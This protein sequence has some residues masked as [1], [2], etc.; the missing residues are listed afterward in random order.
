M[1]WLASFPRSG[2]TFFRNVLYEV[3]G[4]ESSTFHIEDHRE[5]DVNYDAYPVA[6]THLLPDQLQP[7]DRSIPSVYIVRDGR[8][9]LVSLAHHR[10]DIA[11]PGSD[12]EHNLLEAVI[13]RG[14]SHFGGWS[15]N[16]EKWLDRADIVIRFED[17]IKDPIGEAEK[18]REI[19]DLPKPDMTRIPNFESLK[20]GRPKYGGGGENFDEEAN[21]KNFRRGQ[22]GSHKEEMAPEIEAIFWKKHGQTMIKLGYEVPSEF[23]K[24]RKKKVLIEGSKFFNEHMD[25]IGR[26]V[27]SLV[28]FLPILMEGQND[29]QIDLLH[30][31]KVIPIVRAQKEKDTNPEQLV[32][33]HSYEQRLLD[34]KARLRSA[35]PKRIY[36]ALRTIYLGGPWRRVLKA[37]RKAV[38]RRQIDALQED[39]SFNNAEYDLI[40]IPVPQGLTKVVGFNTKL[41]TT[42]HDT[43]HLA[44][45]NFHENENILETEE[46]MQLI[47]NMNSSIL[48]VSECTRNDLI[49]HYS[50]SGDNITVVY[51]GID[52]DVFHPRQRDQKNAHIDRM[53]DLPERD[54]ILSLSTLE[55]RKNIVGTLKAF[56]LMKKNHPEIDVDLVIAGRR[57]W[58]WDK[59][60]SAEGDDDIRFTGYIEEEHLPYLYGQAKIFAY[61]SH[62]EGFGLPLIEAM[63]CGTPVVYGDNS[64]M[65]EIIGEYGIAV[66]PDAYEPMSEAFYRLLMNEVQWRALSHE[67]RSH[68]NKFTWLKCAYHTS[69]LYE[70][71][72]C[73]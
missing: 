11:E 62:Y 6:K 53:Y 29:W 45:P 49:K 1:I 4:L 7:S 37:L 71:I 59:I 5:L 64:A 8:D 14:D 36:N 68:A 25:G 63:G 17:L 2:N 28:R 42:V 69:K 39:L 50:W 41:L 30:K 40:H 9:A 18:L 70:K 13:A 19:I 10:K 27:S 66:R 16:V 44:L 3:Y 26:Y 61:V 52:P 35:L 48:A 31:N 32:L 57:G 51:E 73:S 15:K 24:F 43:T 58:Q 34:L 67:S 20:Y 33:E 22:Q 12:F 55:P 23:Q 56:R 54:F 38:S 65:R 21:L 47:K 60:L 46:G 72:I